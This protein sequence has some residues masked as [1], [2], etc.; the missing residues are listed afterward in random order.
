[1]STSHIESLKKK[2]KDLFINEFG[3]FSRKGH[4]IQCGKS[5]EKG[6][7]E[8]VTDVSRYHNTSEIGNLT[9]SSMV[10]EVGH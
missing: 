8:P 2:K 6:N 7:E 1:M 5:T 9:L 10:I 3:E 4:C